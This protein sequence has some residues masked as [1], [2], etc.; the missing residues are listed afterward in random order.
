MLQ[1]LEEE[2]TVT[3]QLHKHNVSVGWTG[4]KI[5]NLQAL[6]VRLMVLKKGRKELV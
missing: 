1:L 6:K 2:Q 5:P 3:G 4:P